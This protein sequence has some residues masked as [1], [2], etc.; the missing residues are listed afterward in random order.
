MSVVVSRVDGVFQMS[1]VLSNFRFICSSNNNITR[2]TKMVNALCTE[3][4]PALVFLEPPS[5]SV[6]SERIPQAYHPF[7]SPS[8]LAGAEVAA[9]LRSL[10]FGYRAEFIQKTAKMLVDAHNVMPA[11]SPKIEPAEEWLRTLREMDTATARS[12]LL[13]FM[14]VGRKVADCVLLMSMDK[15][16]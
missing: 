6:S 16:R 15:V 11:T 14:G 7:P 3:Y 9:K 12:E 1:A 2:I 4:S 8:V 13:K 5:E 10:G